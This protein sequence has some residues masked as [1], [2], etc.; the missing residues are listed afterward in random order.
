[1]QEGEGFGTCGW[2]ISLPAGSCRASAVPGRAGTGQ[3]RVEADKGQKAG[4]QKRTRAGCWIRPAKRV[5]A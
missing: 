2:L 5:A 1:M 4:P 3:Y